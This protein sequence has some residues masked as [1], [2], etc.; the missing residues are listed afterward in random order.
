MAMFQN[1]S[2]LAA[3]REKLRNG[4]YT[5]VINRINYLTANNWVD[6]RFYLLLA[7]AYD[8]LGQ[9]ED[10]IYSAGQAI[11][12]APQDPR[13][14]VLRGGAYLHQ[15]NY[16]RAQIDINTALKAIKETK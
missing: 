4:Q 7:I 3:L 6:D 15:K 13:A 11:A 14:Y 9:E 5:D 2:A 1:P 12:V 8:G 10:V 16:E